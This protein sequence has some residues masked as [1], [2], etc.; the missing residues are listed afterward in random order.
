MQFVWQEGQAPMAG[1][2]EQNKTGLHRQ[3][4]APWG[5]KQSSGF[6]GSAEND[7][8]KENPR[9]QDK[10]NNEKRPLMQQFKIQKCKDIKEVFT[11]DEE[12]N[13]KSRRYKMKMLKNHLNFDA[14][15]QNQENCKSA[16]NMCRK[17]QHKKKI[18]FFDE[19]KEKCPMKNWKIN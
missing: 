16:K 9:N 18:K 10:K 3:S 19:N 6:T 1:K 7:I 4:K 2:T 14:A 17:H 5:R 13:R 8:K 11:L 15:K 12:L